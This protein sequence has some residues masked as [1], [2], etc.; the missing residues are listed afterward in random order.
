M[1]K[2]LKGQSLPS[3]M[4][5]LELLRTLWITYQKEVQK[6]QNGQNNAEYCKYCPTRQNIIINIK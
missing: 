5:N 1:A 4:T 2:A 6:C 3:N